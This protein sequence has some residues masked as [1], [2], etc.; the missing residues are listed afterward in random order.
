MAVP[1]RPF[2]GDRVVEPRFIP[3]GMGEEQRRAFAKIAH[4]GR[5][6]AV[7]LYT[8]L[9]VGLECYLHACGV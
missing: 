2:A 4:R 9:G 8:L 5:V 1:A 6:E 3:A 7:H